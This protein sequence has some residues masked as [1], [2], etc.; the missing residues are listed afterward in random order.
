MLLAIY[1]AI[2][3]TVLAWLCNE[4]EVESARQFA[5]WALMGALW[6]IVLVIVVARAA[7]RA[8]E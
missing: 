8:A 2:G 6:P 3:L 7:H 4:C 5:V 1:A